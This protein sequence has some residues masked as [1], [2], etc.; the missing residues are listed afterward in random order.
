MDQSSTIRQ[1]IT[2][3]KNG[4]RTGARRLI[5]G[6]LKDDPRNADAWVVMAQIVEDRSEAIACV[7]KALSFR[8][9]DE[10]ARRYLEYLQKQDTNKREHAPPY[11]LIATLA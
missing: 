6:V 11:L 4:D 2:L 5:S 7:K 10:H 3:S 1:A 8:P 9:D